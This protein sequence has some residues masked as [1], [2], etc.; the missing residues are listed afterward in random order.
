M[1]DAIASRHLPVAELEAG[2]PEVRR[3]PQGAGT[4]ELVVRRP[5]VDQREILAEGHL[6]LAVG[7]VGDSWSRRTS[8]R[9]PDGSPN[10]DSQLNV[11]NARF[12]ALVAGPD[13]HAWALAGDQLYVDLDLSVDA[14]PAGTRL[15]VGERA[16]VEV[17]PEP[18]TGCE[19]FAARFGREAHKLVWSQRGV[20]WRLRGLNARVVVPG[21][22]RPGDAVLVLPPADHPA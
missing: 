4:L 12:A 5:E 6:D 22:V 2:L 10:P 17:T 9:T 20:R 1:T 21:T 18:H 15:A 3:S 11:I 19:K 8:R 13:H 16:V 14:L 7:L